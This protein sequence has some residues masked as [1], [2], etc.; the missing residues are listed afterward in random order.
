MKSESTNSTL[1]SGSI[2][3]VV[4]CAAAG[5]C[6]LIFV[7]AA[8]PS[9]RLATTAAPVGDRLPPEQRL[10]VHGLK[11]AGRLAESSWIVHRDSG[12]ER[13]GSQRA[14][15]PRVPI[16]VRRPSPLIRVAFRKAA[17]PHSIHAF[18]FG[19]ATTYRAKVRTLEPMPIVQLPYG[20]RL[21][22][23]KLVKRDRRWLVRVARAPIRQR[24]KGRGS[25]VVG[26]L[27]E[28]RDEEGCEGV[29]RAIWTYRLVLNRK[30][31]RSA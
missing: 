6:G 17:R 8:H 9:A 3:S 25:T 18:A 24:L 12:C 7:G 10:I 26:V 15:V 11:R 20:S 14:W 30:A 31:V 1:I 27:G 5:L 4:G 28:W 21:I 23:S 13:T 29:Q 19:P 22:K 16:R 2:L